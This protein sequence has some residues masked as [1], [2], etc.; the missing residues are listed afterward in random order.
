MPPQGRRSVRSAEGVS[1]GAV[2]IQLFRCCWWLR[3]RGCSFGS[4]KSALERDGT[5]TARGGPGGARCALLV[6]AYHE[7]SKLSSSNNCQGSATPG[8]RLER[9]LPVSSHRCPGQAQG[10]V[11]TGV[12]TFGGRGQ[13]QG[14]I[15]TGTS[16][17]EVGKVSV[18]TYG[19]YCLRFRVHF[20]V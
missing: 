2:V 20:R 16:T 3:W 8:K 5:W 17:S 4:G 18:K 11:P 15:P 1:H 13:A 9:R 10:T 6:Q 14:T 7:A 12:F 19:I